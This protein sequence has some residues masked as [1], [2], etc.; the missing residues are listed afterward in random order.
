MNFEDILYSTVE[1]YREKYNLEVIQS[2]DDEQI[3]K[4]I[5][6]ME[7]QIEHYKNTQHQLNEYQN[8]PEKYLKK[9]EEINYNH[10]IQLKAVN[11]LILYLESTLRTAKIEIKER[12]LPGLIAPAYQIAKF[13]QTLK[14][15]IAEIEKL[16][17]EKENIEKK[18]ASIGI[19][20]NSIP[21][22]SSKQW[23]GNKSEFCEFVKKEYD[24]HKG[25]YGSLREATFILF[26]KYSFKDKSWTKEKCY[27]LLVQKQ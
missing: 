13:A 4:L 10:K 17:K 23:N 19:Q 25:Q 26:A 9:P 24:D 11:E 5:Q 2:A 27:N 12:E 22:E 1:A 14:G 3:R 16:K 7:I 15:N 18:E 8:N 20:L 6:E 21:E